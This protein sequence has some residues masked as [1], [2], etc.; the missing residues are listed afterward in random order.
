[1]RSAEHTGCAEDPQPSRI[2]LP[3]KPY[4]LQAIRWMRQMEGLNLNSLFW[5]KRA[6]SDGG[7]YWFAPDLGEGRLEEPPTASGGLLCDEMGMGKTVELLG[8]VCAAPATVEQLK[9][10]GLAKKHE[11]AG[12]L[13]ASRATLI[14]VPPAL[15]SQWVNEVKKSIVATNPLSVKVFVTDKEREELVPLRKGSLKKSE[16]F[17]ASRKQSLSRLADHD[18]VIV[19]YNTM[20]AGGARQGLYGTPGDVNPIEQIRWTRVAVWNQPVRRVHPTILH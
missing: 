3:M 12:P 1:M 13:V 17:F 5:E 7:E 8:L 10:P 14:V 11:D 6:F 9:A 15:V 18:I 19:T 4:Q 16:T 20:L 2:A